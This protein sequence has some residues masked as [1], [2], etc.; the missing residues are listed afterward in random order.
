[1]FIR[2]EQFF[3]DSTPTG[4]KIHALLVLP[5][6]DPKAIV[7]LAHGMA[8]YKERYMPLMEALVGEGYACAIN[9]HRGHGRSASCKEQLGHLGRDGAG[10]LTVDMFTLTRLITERFPDRPLFLFGHSMGA[11]A[12][13]CY[14]RIDDGGLSGLILCGSTVKNPM[15]PLALALVKAMS[16]VLG[17]QHTSKFVDRLIFGRHNKAFP[18]AKSSFAWLNSDEASVKAYDEDP[19]CGFLFTLN[20]YGGL[21]N[22]LMRAYSVKGWRMSKPGLPI[23]MLSGA[24][25]PCMTNQQK[26]REAAQHLSA[27]GYQNVEL[28]IYENMRHEILHEPG[29]RQVYQDIINFLN[30]AMPS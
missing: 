7:Q 2:Q 22:L 17:Q 20:G 8:E 29:N 12:A 11:L 4:R 30:N 6:E 21:I 27:R 3:Y 13:R 1:M 9:D 19:M 26:L 24:N 15:A 14:A 10:A 23:L 18:D 28:K 16:L 5:E 25:D